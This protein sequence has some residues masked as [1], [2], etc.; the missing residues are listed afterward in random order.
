M[1]F[2]NASA[3]TAI[4]NQYSWMSSADSMAAA[5]LTDFFFTCP[6]RR[7]AAAIAAQPTAKPVYLYEFEYLPNWIDVDVLGDYHT[8]EL[9]FVFGAMPP[10][11]RV[12]C[13]VI[14][15]CSVNCSHTSVRMCVCAL[16]LHFVHVTI[17][18]NNFVL[19]QSL[20]AAAAHVQCD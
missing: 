8:T 13:G 16:R 3:T 15:R 4:L 19:R 20:A 17:I 1:H 9:E 10:R 5:I 18:V 6:A 2:F 14:A 11:R 12:C 7:V